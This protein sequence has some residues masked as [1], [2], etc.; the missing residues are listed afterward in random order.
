MYQFN[1]LKDTVMSYFETN[2]S[3]GPFNEIDHLTSKNID[4]IND[5]QYGVNIFLKRNVR[6]NFTTGIEFSPSPMFFRG[7]FGGRLLNDSTTVD[8]SVD[9]SHDLE[10]EVNSQLAKNVTSKVYANSNLNKMGTNRPDMVGTIC[11]QTPRYFSELKMTNKND[12]LV[13]ISHLQSVARNIAV[14]FEAYY[15]ASQKSG[16]GSLA[17]RYQGFRGKQPFQ[18]CST[19]NVMGDLSISFFT[20]LMPAFIDLATRY[21]LNTNN[22]QSMFEIGSNIDFHV[23]VGQRHVPISLVL[24]TSSTFVHSARFQFNLPYASVSVGTVISNKKPSFG[25][26]L[27]L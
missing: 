22:L 15:K 17:A 11:Y 20:S 3:P 26:T 13:G 2:T 27:S 8:L 7:S 19:Y 12:G 6:N 14:G 21:T 23:K 18:V 10:V 9:N 24:R 25:L 5:F 1:K 4:Y 16:G